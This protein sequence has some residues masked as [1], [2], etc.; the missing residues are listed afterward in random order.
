MSTSLKTARQTLATLTAEYSRRLNELPAD[1]R[2]G[3]LKSLE[4]IYGKKIANAEAE[5]RKFEAAATAAAPT[6][7]ASVTS[8]P[9]T[10]HRDNA[11]RSWLADMYAAQRGGDIEA[12][13]RLQRNNAEARALNSSTTTGGDFLPPIWAGSY[14]AEVKRA[15]RVISSLMRPLPLP[16]SGETIT[17]PR[18]TAGATV[19]V[20]TAD[21]QTLS[22]TDAVTASLTVPVCTVAGYAD[23]S[24]QV[25]ERSEPGL[26]Q[27]LLGDLFKA[28]S[29]KIESYAINGSGANG[30]PQGVLG[31]SGINTIT[32]TDS[33]P[34][35]A[36]IYPKLMDAVRQVTEAVFEPTV[37]YVMTARRLAWFLAA[38]DNSNRP[39]VVPS[40]QGPYN[41][42]GVKSDANPSFLDNLQP[43]AYLG[44][45]PV[46]VS[47]LIPKTLGSGTNE[48]RIISG[49]FGEALIWEEPAGPRTFT[50]EG[51]LSQTAGIR[52]QCLGYVALTW[53]RYPSATSVIAGSGLS[54]PT[55]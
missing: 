53:G 1:A 13:A 22:N 24:R 55:L 3:D 44:G 43:A 31:L 47:E 10:Y 46:F 52:I 51:I 4:Q 12:L 14:F 26:D 41:A 25:I 34:T 6:S 36:E 33:T 49:A 42:F 16:P 30:Q 21:N 9:K 20:Q 45:L 39:L 5:V 18:M 2:T 50:F 15:R 19:A 35:V 29:S 28:Y 11:S 23:C 40:G 32:Y 48:D 17:V 7:R 37:G 54:A 38:V 8:E 27:L